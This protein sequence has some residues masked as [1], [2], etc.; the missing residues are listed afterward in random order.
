VLYILYRYEV[1]AIEEIL[2]SHSFDLR[3]R[4]SSCTVTS[5]ISSLRLSLTMATEVD[6]DGAKPYNWDEAVPPSPEVL[7]LW[8][9]VGNGLD[10]NQTGVY[11]CCVVW[12]IV[13][14][15]VI[16]A[17]STSCTCSLRGFF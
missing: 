12:Y 1:G 10:K 2:P 11:R 9:E 6:D 16:P 15:S 7:Q 5:H 17:Y 13:I 14:R 3:R 4:S 8:T